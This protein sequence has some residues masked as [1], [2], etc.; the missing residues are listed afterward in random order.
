MVQGTVSPACAQ[1]EMLQLCLFFF[2]QAV[3]IPTALGT[4]DATKK[5]VGDFWQHWKGKALV[6]GLV[7]PDL[8][9]CN[10]V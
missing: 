4:G 1:A 2:Q 7:T 8:C 3:H 9:P 10:R 6:S 5:I